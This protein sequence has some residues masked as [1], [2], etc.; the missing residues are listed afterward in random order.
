MRAWVLLGCAGVSLLAL[1]MLFD[2]S[3]NHPTLSLP[4]PE[5]GLSISYPPRTL[6][7][8]TQLILQD[9]AHISLWHSGQKL[10]PSLPRD[11][12][13]LEFSLP[14]GHTYVYRLVKENWQDLGGLKIWVGDRITTLDMLAKNRGY[15]LDGDGELIARQN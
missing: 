2:L 4:P 1:T 9:A 11:A 7:Q 3:N 8:Q 10:I 6:P 12:S 5:P 14:T 15:A 13:Y